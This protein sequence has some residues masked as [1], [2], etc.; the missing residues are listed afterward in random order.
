MPVVTMELPGGYRCCR[1][2]LDD[3]EAILALI[4]EYNG[5]FVGFAD[6]TLD[7]VRDGL[8]EPGFDPTVDGWLVHGSGGT[9]AGYGW[10][11][12]KGGSDM[13]D[14]DVVAGD[15]AVAD[16]LW[17]RALERAAEIGAKAGRDLVSVDIGIYQTD[18]TQQARAKARA[19]VPATTFQRMRID[20][21]R[22]PPEPVAPD[23]VVVRTGTGDEALR[24]DAHRV[25]QHAMAEHF[26]YVE[27]SF[28][29][30]HAGIESSATHD[31]AQLR[32]AY[33]GGEPTAIVQ[34]S[35]QFVEDENC[36]YVATV[37]VVPDARGRGLAK[38]LLRQ[39]FADDFRRGRRG[40]TLHV[41]TDNVTPALGLYVGVGMRSV[42]AIDVWR[43]Q[44]TTG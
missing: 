39:A 43:G 38:L 4:S 17:A 24:R 32:V 27:K 14:I 5:A 21:D 31:W 18:V 2:T 12:G 16:W 3:A 23:D 9:V 33:I 34:G 8:T 35:D 10:A 20:F 41:D 11:Y 42:L 7:D 19:F 15:A 36:G 6:F 44:L 26:G 40:T 37:A 13:V 29:A 25:S 28:A 1:P 22:A 30:W